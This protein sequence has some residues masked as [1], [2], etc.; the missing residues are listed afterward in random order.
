MIFIN[1]ISFFGLSFIL[2]RLFS[3][4][5]KINPFLTFC[6]LDILLYLSAYFG[7]L[8]AFSD[9]VLGI[10]ITYFIYFFYKK[11]KDKYFLSFIKL[12]E[13]QF[14]LLAISLL[15]F[16]T[17]TEYFSYFNFVDDYSHWGRVTYL[18][19]S[20]KE[21]LNS[22][23]PIWFM[24]YPPGVALLNSFFLGHSNFSV[25]NAMFV[26]GLL[27][28]F[29]IYR[30][31]TIS[32]K[33]SQKLFYLNVLF[34]VSMIFIFGGGLHTLS[35]D[36]LLGFIFGTLI[37]E[38]LSANLNTGTNIKRTF[39]K[40]NFL[41]PLLFLPLVKQVGLFFSGLLILFFG[42]HTIL[43]KRLFFLIAL[44]LTS[45]LTLL[46]YF[47]WGEVVSASN[48]PRAFNKYSIDV[49]SI[50]NVFDSTLRTEREQLT[51]DNFFRAP[52]DPL[53]HF[54]LSPYYWL[55]LTMFFYKFIF[56]TKN[57]NRL[58]NFDL[59]YFTF[60]LPVGM[61]L[62]SFFLLL[63]YLFIWG[64]YEGPRLASFGRYL[65]TYSIGMLISIFFMCQYVNLDTHKKIL[66]VF[67]ILVVL[68]A[69][70]QIG[71][72][73]SFLLKTTGIINKDKMFRRTLNLASF[74]SSHTST[75]DSI[76]F[77]KQRSDGT[78]NTIFNYGIMPRNSN[79]GCWS[80]G[81][82]YSKGDVWTCNLNRSDIMKELSMYDYI[83]VDTSDDNLNRVF[84][85]FFDV[86]IGSGD[87][88]KI[89]K[90][91]NHLKLQFIANKSL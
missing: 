71:N 65:S 47:S 74:V 1:L 73:I 46:I 70:P 23:D 14:I 13:N 21:F 10:G 48:A 39:G 82:P 72:Q 11:R 32:N 36:L 34:Y 4:K 81:I 66:N 17:R 59:K 91:G 83:F 85:N 29:T 51:I 69:I 30:L 76:Y 43:K 19:W 20:K 41:I 42:I 49:S 89:I 80:I 53:L 84:F 31:L 64:D 90:H 27:I 25:N 33:G 61:I 68:V 2:A 40:F 78:E 26:Q 18:Y 67:I 60:W 77:L 75:N 62:Y 37:V 12:P 57:I 56:Y 28:I 3:E 87:L 79:R 9:V 6:I 24:D 55:A 16:V 50:L 5:K 54:H 15:F 7:F 88:F 38:Y 8:S 52:F 35:V 86:K 44:I 45:V 22:H 63:L 58:S